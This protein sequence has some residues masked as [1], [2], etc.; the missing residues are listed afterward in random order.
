MS[1]LALG[2]SIALGTG[3]V[4]HIETVAKIGASS[5]WISKH[6]PK[7]EYSTV[8][9]SAGVNDGN[10]PHCIREI[11]SQVKADRV[12]WIRPIKYTSELVNQIAKE[13]GDTVVTYSVGSDGLHPNDYSQ[14]AHKIKGR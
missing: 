4:M 3:Q 6:I 2:D 1:D 7:G 9:I 13:F 8:I 12:I 5:C 11:R 14:I 10:G